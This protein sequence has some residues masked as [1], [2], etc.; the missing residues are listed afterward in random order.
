MAWMLHRVTGLALVL[1]LYLHLYNL[2]YL[3]KGAEEYNEHTR[4]VSEGWFY[5]TLT[6]ILIL[7]VI[8]HGIN[9]IRITLFDIGIG[10]GHHRK[11]WYIAMGLTA[12]LAAVSAYAIFTFEPIVLS[13]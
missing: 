1:Y 2:S 10:V 9:G 11:L 13:D 8:Y 4:A 3:T 12:I 5:L 7:G 6:A